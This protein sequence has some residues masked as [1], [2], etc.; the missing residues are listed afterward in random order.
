MTLE[1]KELSKRIKAA[2][3]LKSLRRIE[4]SC[5]RIYSAGFL[6]PRELVVLDTML[7]DRAIKFE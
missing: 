4:I 5:H 3:D 7:M 2:K 6:S 1:Y